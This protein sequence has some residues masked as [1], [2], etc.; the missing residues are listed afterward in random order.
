[1]T[2]LRKIK[3]LI[4]ILRSIYHYKK[5]DLC[6]PYL[7]NALWTELTN[8]CNLRC[9]M[10]PN[11]VRA[12]KKSGFMDIELYKK[13]IDEAKVF[14][15]PSYEEGWGVVVFEAIACG[16]APVVYDLPVFREIFGDKMSLTPPGDFSLLAKNILNFLNN[17]EKRSYG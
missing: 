11:S 4:T 14:V 5:G 8:V 1:M 6:L 10:C 15:L 13:I 9:I 17:E 2:I 16:L 7:P 12:Q 3:H